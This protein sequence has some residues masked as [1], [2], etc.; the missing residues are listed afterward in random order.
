M[1]PK[2]EYPTMG[3]PE[4]L[5]YPDEPSEPVL[6]STPS[7]LRFLTARLDER[8]EAARACFTE[9][10]DATPEHVP[11]YPWGMTASERTFLVH[12]QPEW[13]IEDCQA[14]R[15]VIE[16]YLTWYAMAHRTVAPGSLVPVV[17]RFAN[18]AESAY[19]MVL[20]EFVLP[21]VEHPDFQ[22]EW[23]VR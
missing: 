20:H 11:T 21:F 7:L 9:P 17:D 2:H 23:L 12:V 18:G 22:P 1:M 14:K 8:E 19:A 6:A 4:Q 16:R 15:R 10:A 13:V 5:D 3:A